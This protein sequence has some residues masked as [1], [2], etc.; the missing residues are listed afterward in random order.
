MSSVQIALPNGQQYDQRT[1]AFIN[2]EFV[3]ATGEA[4]DEIDPSEADVNKAVAA[5]R[6]AFQGNSR[7]LSATERGN[8]LSRLAELIYRDRELF[9]AIDAYDNGKLYSVTLAAHLD[10]SYDVFKYY[11]GWADKSSGKTIETSS[12]KLAYVLQEPLVA[13]ALACGNVVVLKPA[14]QTPLSALYLGKLV[15]EAGLPPGVVNIIH[16]LGPVAGRCLAE[17]TEVDKIAFTESTA[18]GRTIMKAPATNLKNITLQLGSA[19][20]GL[21]IIRGKLDE[22]VYDAFVSRFVE[23]TRENA[24]AMIG[25]AVVEGA[26]Q[27][28]QLSRGQYEKV[29]EY[30]ELEKNEGADLVYGGMRHGEKGYFVEPTAFAKLS[31]WFPS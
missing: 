15:I 18:T 10:E 30:I 28:P 2:N 12:G 1:G 5:A 13:P 20:L 27:G 26:Y 25:R 8:L 14:E 29:L 7:S 4:F 19:M 6:T 21:W 22:G 31:C 16:G 24:G 9:A 23:V 3:P 11:A 17:Y